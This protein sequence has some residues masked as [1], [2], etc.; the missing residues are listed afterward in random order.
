MTPVIALSLFGIINLF[1]GFT[2]KRQSLQ[3]VTLLFI[4]CSMALTAMDWNH[5]YLWFGDMMKTN[6]LS[7]NFSL[8]IQLAGLLVVAFSNGFGKDE[9]YT[10]PAEYYA[11][12]LFS[13][14]GA[15]LMVSFQNLIML[16]VGLEILS[17]A[18]YVLTGSDKRNLR[19][20]EAALKYFLMG[21]FATGFLLFGIALVYGSTRSLYIS[22][23]LYNL[24]HTA[25]ESLPSFLYAGIILMGIG[26]L[27]KISAAPFHFWTPDV[28]EGAPTIF[29]MFMS[30]VVKTA[31]FAAIYH[32]LDVT[33]GGFQKNWIITVYFITIITLILGNISAAYQQSAKRML[34]FSSIS[35][36]GYMLLTVC[37]NQPSTSSNILYY[38]LAYTL[39]TAV[40]FAVLMVVAEYQTGRTEKPENFDALNGLAKNN[41]SLAF[42]FTVALLSLAGIPLTAGFWGKFFVFTDMFNK[43]LTYPIIIAVLMSAVGIYYYFKGIISVYFNSGEI[44]KI[45]TS[46]L[47]KIALWSA[48][49]GTL[50][51]GIYPT[52]LKSIF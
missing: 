50:V 29:T 42:A 37:A 32:I 39:A 47:F 13:L 25:P 2:F 1:L 46:F 14:V 23:I 15:L 41:P 22:G 31:G 33:F 9:V 24:S 36:A 4:I 16:F 35:H 40:S 34:A 6:N 3:V 44:E 8:I 20:N 7:I 19:S 26:L 11:I 45:E 43:N 51:L 52:L 28:Y 21:S 10:Q 48:C 12:L 49:I 30:T 5:E 38:S 27:F 18:M 17:V